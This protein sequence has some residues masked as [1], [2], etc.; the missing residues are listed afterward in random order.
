M[1]FYDCRCMV[2]GVSLKGADAALVL[3]HQSSDHY[4]PLAL[5]VKG[6]Y[7]RL[8][9]IDGIDEDA[10]TQSV[11]RFFQESLRSGVFTVDEEYLRGHGCF[12]IQTIEDLLQCFERNMNDGE[13]VA[14][15][16]GQSV[17]FA[18]I[19]R[20]VWDTIAEAAPTPVEP[21]MTSFKRLFKASPVGLEIYARS[22]GAVSKHI[23]ELAAVDSLLNRRRLSWQPSEA[24]GQDYPEEMRQ[25]LDEARGIFSDSPTILAALRRYEQEIG[26]LLTDE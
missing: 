4:V 13:G 6:N 25:Y 12:P 24:T 1:G 19:A 14:V 11:M 16:N 5:A 17:V 8:G 9:S 7:N 3:L 2:T 26:D 20:S 10:N 18:L 21:A 22:V 15:L 23:G